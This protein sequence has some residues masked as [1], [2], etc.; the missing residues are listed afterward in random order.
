MSNTAE[1]IKQEIK[2]YMADAQRHLDSLSSKE[3]KQ[4]EEFNKKNLQMSYDLDSGDYD[5]TLL[6]D[7]KRK[8][9]HK[10]YNQKKLEED[11][12]EHER[13]QDEKG[14]K[15]KRDAFKTDYDRINKFLNKEQANILDDV[16]SHEEYEHIL[17]SFMV[18]PK[19]SALP[20]IPTTPMT[21]K[22]PFVA[23][24]PPEKKKGRK[25]NDEY[26]GG[27]SRVF[28][29]KTTKK[30]ST[31]RSNKVHQRRSRHRK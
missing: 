17:N 16:K 31:R 10:M 19:M 11:E 5:N 25:D 4:L 6:R 30:R 13:L 28:R 3:K 20:E 21:P 15:Q 18:L 7:D 1:D 22:T 24:T 2:E 27:R 23:R 26:E 29:R 14:M 9:F 8:E 12:L